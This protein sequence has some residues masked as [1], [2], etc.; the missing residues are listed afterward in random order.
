MMNTE[1]YRD[2]KTSDLLE[3]ERDTANAIIAFSAIACAFL[4][5]A[6]VTMVKCILDND[7]TVY[8]FT[9]LSLLIANILMMWVGTCTEMYN[10]VKRE[11]ERRAFSYDRESE[12]DDMGKL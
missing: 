3:E 9:A 6:M 5:I 12:H 1:W 11:L 2:L 10:V 7:P 8:I 4:L